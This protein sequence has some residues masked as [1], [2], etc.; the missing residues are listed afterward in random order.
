[1]RALPFVFK[2]FLSDPVAAL[3]SF[4]LISASTYRV[5]LVNMQGRF[6]SGTVQQ[7]PSGGF[8]RRAPQSRGV[9]KTLKMR[10][11]HLFPVSSW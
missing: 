8:S 2:G 9:Y 4:N 10:D 3:H 7:E 5:T 1:M 11:C 6:F